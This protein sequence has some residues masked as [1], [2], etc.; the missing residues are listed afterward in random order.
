MA[1]SREGNGNGKR[2]L[3]AAGY[4]KLEELFTYGEFTACVMVWLPLLGAV[5]LAHHRDPV[6]RV[7]GRWFRR[8]GK[9]TSALSPLWRFSVEGTPPRDITTRPYVVVANHVSMAD[10]FL[11]SWFD[12][13]MQWVGKEELFRMPVL[14]WLFRLAGDIPLRRGSGD[15]VR[16]MLDACRHALDNGLSV[17]LFPEGTRSHDASVASFKDGAFQLAVER[18]VPV[19]PLAIA[20]TERCVRRSGRSLGLGRARA[21]A[22]VL[23]PIE[24]RRVATEAEPDEVARVRDLARDRIAEAVNELEGRLALTAAV[25]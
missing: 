13:D 24:T 8:M 10:P 17:M 9:T 19:L 16:A 5:R 22:R 11:L 20:G 7:A 15:S 14:G 2:R 25:D 23:E 1:A 6:P 4:G 21:I 3:L 18:G 12:W